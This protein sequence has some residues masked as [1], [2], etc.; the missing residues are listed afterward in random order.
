MLSPPD[1]PP[2][3]DTDSAAA[4]P[5]QSCTE[6]CAGAH[7]Q[8]VTST[9]ANMSEAAAEWQEPVIG[10]FV[11]HNKLKAKRA[12]LPA[13]IMSSTYFAGGDIEDLWVGE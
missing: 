3:E 11:V 1:S 2:Y 4:A 6:T 12:D 10:V 8:Q 7:Q 13:D 9:S 5:Q